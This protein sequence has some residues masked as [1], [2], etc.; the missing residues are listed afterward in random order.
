MK[1]HKKIVSILMAFF[2]IMNHNNIITSAGDSIP[3]IDKIITEIPIYIDIHSIAE[4]ADDTYSIANINTDFSTQ[5]QIL[6]SNDEKLALYESGIFNSTFNKAAEL[7]NAGSTITGIHFLIPDTETT[8]YS[9]S[10]TSLVSNDW[11][12][13]TYASGTYNGFE[14]RYVDSYIDGYTTPMPL[15]NIGTVSWKDVIEIGL[16]ALVPTVFSQNGIELFSE[17]TEN[18]LTLTDLISASSVRPNITYSYSDSS[19]IKYSVDFRHY[20]RQFYMSDNDDRVYG[21]DYYIPGTA[22]KLE[23]D[24]HIDYRYPTLNSWVSGGTNIGERIIKSTDGFNGNNSIYYQFIQSY[25]SANSAKYYENINLRESLLEI[26]LN[27]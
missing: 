24:N 4:D 8:D 7:I 13:H 15:N 14:F 18:V 11:R 5:D 9:T 3:Y 17:I 19:Y 2:L 22:E 27:N 25:Y 21:Y 12:N 16:L 20:S 10:V 23:I 26:M 1:K 6:L